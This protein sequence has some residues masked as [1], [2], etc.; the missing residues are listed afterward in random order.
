MKSSL[1]INNQIHS[2]NMNLNG[3]PHSD[4][5][6]KLNLLNL[7]IKSYCVERSEKKLSPQTDH[8]NGPYG[9]H[10]HTWST[11]IAVG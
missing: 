1:L 5:I 4:R 8:H 3:I 9:L 7:E 11:I 6:V 10:M 2:H